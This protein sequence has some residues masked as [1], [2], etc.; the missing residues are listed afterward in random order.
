MPAIKVHHTA[1]S[2]E[3][4]DGP[5]AKKNA[6]EDQSAAYYGKI[7]AWQ[8]PDQ[9]VGNKSSAWKLPHHEVSADGTPGAANMKGCSAA[10]GALNGA[11]GGADIPEADRAGVH[12]HIAAHMMDGDMEPPELKAEENDKME[13]RTFQVNDFRIADDGDGERIEGHAAVF[14]QDTPIMFFTERIRPGA[15]KKTLREGDIRALYNHDPNLVLGRNKAGTL[16]LKEDEEGLATVIK[17]PN[18]TYAADLKEVMRRGDVDQMSFGF[19][20]VKEEWDESNPNMP[21]RML[22]EVKLW[23]VSVVTFP[24]YPQTSAAVRQRMAAWAQRS[25][26]PSRVDSGHSDNQRDEPSLTGH[27][28]RERELELLKI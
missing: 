18:T 27:S 17:P 1:T 23:D 24:A 14:N 10:M 11:R 15:F 19:E 5:A 26:E 25:A 6:K 3:S 7:F 22:V 8:D 21:V 4:W 12:R 20:T 9:D 28:A 16:K 13:R 2:T